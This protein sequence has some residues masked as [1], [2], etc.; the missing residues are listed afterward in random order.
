MFKHSN[1]VNIS[2]GDSLSLVQ[3]AESNLLKAKERLDYLTR[4]TYLIKLTINNKFY[5][6][7]EDDSLSQKFGGAIKLKRK[8]YAQKELA[9]YIE[10]AELFGC[11]NVKSYIV[12][13]KNLLRN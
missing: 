13:E 4:K 7:C 10:R 9:L 5:F 6:L 1:S 8:C 2:K 11:E 12:I 3:Q